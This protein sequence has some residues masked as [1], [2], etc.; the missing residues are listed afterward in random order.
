[1]D[2]GRVLRA[3]LA[4]SL[5]MVRATHIAAGIGKTLAI[6]FGILGLF[7]PHVGPMF[8]LLAVFVYIG[9]SQEARSVEVQSFTKGVGIRDVMIT[10]FKALSQNATLQEALDAL[11]SSYQHD[12]PVVDADGG[13]LGIL[14]RP[15]MLTALQQSGAQVSVLSLM[16]K[17][18]E[19]VTLDTDLDQ[20]LNELDRLNA[21]VVPVADQFGRVIGLV[22]PENVSEMIMVREAAR[23]GPNPQ[24]P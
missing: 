13:L 10:N 18:I 19:A 3:V 8:I 4:K 2:G 14:T 16:R 12:F 5:P 7:S 20:A 11:L 23:K 9:A 1:M 21:P 22:V 17:D 6:C 15:Q 24:T